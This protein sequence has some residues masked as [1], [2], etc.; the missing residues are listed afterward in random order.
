MSGQSPRERAQRLDL[1][2]RVAAQKGQSTPHRRGQPVG[3]CQADPP[4]RLGH[5]DGKRL[6][7]REPAPDQRQNGV[8]G[9][10]DDRGLGV[11]VPLPR[12][13]VRHQSGFGRVQ[14]A[15]FGQRD[16]TPEQPSP[17]EDGIPGPAGQV[18]DLGRRGQTLVRGSRIPHR[19]QPPVQHLGEGPR[20]VGVPGEPNRLVDEFPPSGRGGRVAEHLS[21]KPHQHASPGGRR[22]RTRRGVLQ[23]PDQPRVE[24]E[25]LTSRRRGE[26]KLDDGV[27]AGSG[28]HG[29]REVESRP[30]PAG[31]EQPD[32]VHSADRHPRQDGSQ[33]RLGQWGEIQVLAGVPRLDSGGQDRCA[34]A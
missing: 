2:C 14:V 10:G 19:V 33:F 8:P 23:Q 11:A 16:E 24:G 27:L 7:K 26:G 12:P 9:Q 31:G 21:G 15:E 17:F 4:S 25:E 6:R 29:R 34:A 28:R 22:Q 13:G 32:R 5:L 1:A 20:V 30:G 3:V 18:D